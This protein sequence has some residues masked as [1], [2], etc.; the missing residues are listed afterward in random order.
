MRYKVSKNLSYNK[1]DV[2][3]ALDPEKISLPKNA[4][5]SSYVFA[6][7]NNSFFKNIEDLCF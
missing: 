5:S 1:K 2:M 3:E 4:L 6:K 7:E